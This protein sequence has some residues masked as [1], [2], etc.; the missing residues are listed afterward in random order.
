MTLILFDAALMATTLLWALCASPVAQAGYETVVIDAGRGDVTLLLPDDYKTGAPLP[1][2]LSLHG[3]GGDGNAFVRYWN[4]SGQLDTQRFIV[5][6]PAGPV[7][8]RDKRF[9]NATATWG[10]V[11]ATAGCSLPRLSRAS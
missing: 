10:S 7:D 6:A 11:T 8:S 9:W 3:V 1:L 4:T 5:A 2:F